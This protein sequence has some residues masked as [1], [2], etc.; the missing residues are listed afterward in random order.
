[1]KTKLLIAICLVTGF[2]N[3]QITLENSYNSPA[4]GSGISSVNLSIAGYKYVIT[5]TKNSTVK[6][7]SLNHSLYK[8]IVLQVPSGFTLQTVGN[9]SQQLFNSDALVEFT[10][11]YWQMNGAN[12]NFGTKVETETNN[13][14]LSL[15]NCISAYVVNTIS[16]GWKLI[17]TIDSTNKWSAKNFDVYSLIGSLPMITSIGQNQPSEITTNLYPNPSSERVRI[18][19]QLPEGISSGEV[20]LFDLNGSELRHY[21]ID[22]NFTS[23]DLNNNDLPSGSYFYNITAGSSSTTK[24]MIIVK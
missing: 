9:I 24:K 4:T 23:L 17:A 16:N 15:P 3:A 12:V 11:T 13:V 18:D 6:L 14:L 20:V 5:D 21:N 10:Y 8:T 22:K 19:Y 7:Y 2:L 1:M